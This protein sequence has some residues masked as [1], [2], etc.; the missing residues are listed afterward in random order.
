MG[1]IAPADPLALSG[2]GQLLGGARCQREIATPEAAVVLLEGE[3]GVDT[4][5][6]DVNPV[7]TL[8]LIRSI[9]DIVVDVLVEDAGLDGQPIL[10]VVEREDRLVAVLATEGAVPEAPGAAVVQAIAV[11]LIDV[12]S[13]PSQPEAGTGSEAF[14]EAVVRPEAPRRIGVGILLALA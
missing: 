4:A 11:Q 8:V 5:P 12:G 1:D 10:A 2:E 9:V 6:V 14:A 7:L 3:D 13:T